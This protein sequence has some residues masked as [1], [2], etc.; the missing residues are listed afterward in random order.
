[1]NSQIFIEL[2]IETLDGQLVYKSSKVMDDI[3]M[4]TQ[5]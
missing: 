4:T 2:L 3:E 5:S 1:L